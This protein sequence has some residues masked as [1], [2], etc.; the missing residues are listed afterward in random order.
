MYQLLQSAR[1]RGELGSAPLQVLQ[2][3][4]SD[5]LHPPPVGGAIE[6]K[7]LADFGERETGEL[8]LADE[9]QPL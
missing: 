6:P 5:A 7:Q 1:D 3:L 9:V 8:C 4:P 2:F